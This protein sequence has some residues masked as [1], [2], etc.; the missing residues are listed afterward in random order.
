MA[1]GEDDDVALH[2]VP[3]VCPIFVSQSGQVPPALESTFQLTLD[4][5]SDT[6]AAHSV[7]AMLLSLQPVLKLV[8]LLLFMRQVP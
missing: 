5:E 7:K 2:C 4:M 6:A 1:P 8:A 3:M